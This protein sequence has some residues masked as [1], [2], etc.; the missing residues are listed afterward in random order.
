VLC[1]PTFR[2]GIYRHVTLK[3]KRAVCA[4]DHAAPPCPNKEHWEID[5]D[6]SIELGGSNDMDN[7]WAQPKGQALVKDKLENRLHRM[8]CA[9]QITLPDAQKCI[10]TNWVKCAERYPQ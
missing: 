5:H 9:G 4:R 7:L 1:A 6:I 3:T 10:A 8:V 2:T